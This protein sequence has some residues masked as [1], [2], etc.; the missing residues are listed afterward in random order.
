VQVVFKEWL[1]DQPEFGNPGLTRAENVIPGDGGYEPF[2]S[3]TANSQT[4]GTGVLQAG[5]ATVSDAGVQFLFVQSGAPIFE[6]VNNG[7]NWT[8]SGSVSAGSVVFTQYDDLVIAAGKATRPRAKTI[9]SSSSFAVLA[10]SGTAPPSNAI[11]V[12]G[13]FVVIGGLSQTTGGAGSLIPHAVQWS[14]IDQPRNWPTPGSATAIASQSGLQEL[15]Q[16]YG[17]VQ[18]I[19][20]GDQFGVILQEGAVNRMTY[21]GPPAVFQFDT[22]DNRQGSVFR[23][24]SIRVGHITYFLSRDGFYKTDGVSVVPIGDGKVDRY[25]WNAWSGNGADNCCWGY[26]STKNMLYFGF[27]TAASSDLDSILAYNVING[28]WSLARETGGFRQFITS[29]PG[30]DYSDDLYAFSVGTQKICGTFSGVP[31]V[32]VLETGDIEINEG[33]RAYVDAVKPH[34]ESVG[35]APSV[36]VAVLHRDSLGVTP[37]YSN[38]ATANS[39]TGFVNMRVDA[40]YI[41]VRETITGNFKK[42]TGFEINARPSGKA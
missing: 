23:Q 22:I 40:K 11:G 24:G 31:G 20:G 37:T 21:V 29:A 14:S 2:A 6:A 33:G 8:A 5:I 28:T 32:A 16:Q 1:P 41:R 9:G 30:T 18:A 12:I 39:R 26:D 3:F 4:V 35:T 38:E 19:H 13:Q 10:S 25:F 17:E 34:V 15:G 27:S 36:T 7:A 42:A